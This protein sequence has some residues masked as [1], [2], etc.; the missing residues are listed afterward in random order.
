M[1][2]VKSSDEAADAL[3]LREDPRLRRVTLAMR[4][5]PDH[6]CRDTAR[7]ITTYFVVCTIPKKMSSWYPLLTG[8]GMPDRNGARPGLYPI[9]NTRACTDKKETAARISYLSLGTNTTA[10]T[11]PCQLVQKKDSSGRAR[12]CTDSEA[13]RNEVIDTEMAPKGSASSDRERIGDIFHKVRSTYK[14]EAYSDHGHV[15]SG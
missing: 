2:Q 6:V 7:S 3:P 9:C 12:V 14:T 13:S 10:Q 5:H 4:L 15:D 11:W 8:P 1:A